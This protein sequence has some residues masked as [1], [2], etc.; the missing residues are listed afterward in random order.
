MP[1]YL[2]EDFLVQILILKTM[3]CPVIN[4]SIFFFTMWL[5]DHDKYEFGNFF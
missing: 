2:A 5:L 4:K 1:K 3:A